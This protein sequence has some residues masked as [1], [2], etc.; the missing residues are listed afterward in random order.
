MSRIRE[1]TWHSLVKS[2]NCKNNFHPLAPARGAR[3]APTEVREWNCEVR[4]APLRVRKRSA[5]PTWV[6]ERYPG[7]EWKSD[8]STGYPQAEAPTIPTQPTN[9]IPWISPLVNTF[10]EN[11][12][13]FFLGKS[14]PQVIH[15]LIPRLV[16]TYYRWNPHGCRLN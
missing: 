7:S 13:T 8:L 1:C 11:N 15:R 5:S 12:L 3:F 10:F 16:S 14:Y 4:V 9:I 2:G 6:L